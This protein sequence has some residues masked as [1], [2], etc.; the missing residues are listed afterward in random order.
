[1]ADAPLAAAAGAAPDGRL[2]VE[3][4][5]VERDAEGRPHV[6]RRA[7]SL[8]LGATV[9]DAVAAAGEPTL[10]AQ[11][12]AGELRAAVFGLHRGADAPLHEGDRVELLGPLIVDPKV[13][14]QRRVEKNRAAA[15]RDR[16][17]RS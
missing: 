15:P 16:W 14:R 10:A 12:A 3:L 7:L 2:A 11:L 17:R 5:W 8:P 6:A 9:G 1:M 4:A 13:A